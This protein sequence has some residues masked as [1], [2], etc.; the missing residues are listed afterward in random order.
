M[1]VEL[2]ITLHA[3]QKLIASSPALYKVIKAGKRF[4]KSRF[5]I[6]ALTQAA[7]LRPGGNFCYIAPT[8]RQAKNIAWREFKNMIPHKYIKRMVENELLI[9]LVNDAEIR[10]LGSDNADSL[11]G[12]K[13]H[14]VIFDEV[15]YQK[16]Y[17]WVNIIQGQLLGEQQADG[18]YSDPGFAIFISSPINP[19]ET[20]GKDI[21][22]WFPQF[23]TEA[24]RKKQSGDTKWDA[25]HFSIYDNPTL[26]RE[27]ID[28]IKNNNTD[29]AWNV[30][31]LA[32]ESAF[33]GHVYSEFK[34]E[35]HVKAIEPKGIFVRGIDWGISH[36]TVGLFAHV[37]K[38]GKKIYF[39]DEYV[40]SDMTISESCGVILKKS[41]DKKPDWTVADPSLHKRNAV[42]LV[43]DI[44]EFNK[45][46]VPCVAGDNNH[47]GYDIVKM[48]LKR[49]LIVV[50][51]KC[52]ILIKQLKELQ[53]TDK[54]D[55][56]CTDVLRYIC[57]RVHDLIFGWRDVP[58]TIKEE[59]KPAG[60]FNLNDPYLFKKKTHENAIVADIR[61]F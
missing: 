58:M 16:K 40:R 6:F 26:S 18:T 14:G 60:T 56:D 59:E 2:P 51:P 15:A 1:N 61:S 27:Q 7:G 35:E 20:V 54:T 30:E 34:Y 32:N 12:I 44:L 17:N 19:S 55:D 50:N 25:W 52:R 41:G 29:D 36:P 21:E 13:M 48:F 38:E 33:A 43:P 11:R 28:D 8:Y 5:S 9:V 39:E 47:R 42:T 10:L 49:G 24:L 46:G 57:V 45:N 4:G 53:W 37:D 31:Y 22:D 23:Y 3:N